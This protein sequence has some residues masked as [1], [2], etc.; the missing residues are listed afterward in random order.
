MKYFSLLFALIFIIG[1]SK[2]ESNTPLNIPDLQWDYGRN[3]YQETIDDTLRDFIVHVPES[4][5]SS[6]AVPLLFMLHGSSG[7]GE[8]FYNISRWVEK[9]NEEN[10]IV[11]FPTALKHPIVENGSNT[12]KWSTPSLEGETEEGH[13][14]KDDEIFFRE[15]I[16]MCKS[17][18]HIDHGRIYACGF[19][20]GGNFTRH[21]IIPHMA[22]EFTAVAISGGFG[23]PEKLELNSDNYLPLYAMIGTK[24]DRI[25]EATG[26][27]QEIPLDGQEFMAHEFY[28]VYAR[29]MAETLN[30][31][32]DYSEEQDPPN[33]NILTFNKSS[34]GQNNEYKIMLIN[35]MGHMFANG[36]NNPKGVIAAD[37]LWPW[38]MKFSS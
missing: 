2:E 11:V 12:T 10:F 38:F 6:E 21:N 8:K 24:D 17:T 25:I 32:A 4:Y 9:S 28:G 13:I 31:E 20:N 30:L 23:V 3:N 37:H 5:D 22:E 16:R 18:F 33:F 27:I 26:T 19:S 34:V 14:I 7:T 29:A 1:C 35:E 15:M 36:T